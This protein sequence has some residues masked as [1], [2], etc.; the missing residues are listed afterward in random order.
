[1]APLSPLVRLINLIV[2]NLYKSSDNNNINVV[3]NAILCMNQH[4]ST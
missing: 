4:K 2:T 3:T 1:M